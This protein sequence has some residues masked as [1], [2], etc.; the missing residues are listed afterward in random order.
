MNIYI[1]SNIISKYVKKQQTDYGKKHTN[2]QL[3]GECNIPSQKWIK[4]EKSKNIE[5]LN[6]GITGYRE[7]Y[8]Q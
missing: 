2:Q 3:Y 5:Y 6:N 7:F 1:P 8:T 4:Q